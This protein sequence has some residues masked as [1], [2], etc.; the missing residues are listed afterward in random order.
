M[1]RSLDDVL[2]ELRALPERDQRE[3]IDLITFFLE[4]RRSELTLSPE[5]IAEVKRRLADDEPIA[6][7]ADVKALFD[8]LTR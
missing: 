8:R 3:A 7:E 4:Q 1:S 2:D 6:S 5:Q